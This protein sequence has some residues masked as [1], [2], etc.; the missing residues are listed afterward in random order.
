MRNMLLHLNHRKTIK[1]LTIMMAFGLVSLLFIQSLSAQNDL[2]IPKPDLGDGSSSM[3]RTGAVSFTINGKVYIGLGKDGS[4][5]HQDLWEYDTISETWTQKADFVGIGRIGAFSMVMNNKAI[6]GTGELAGGSRTNTVYKYDP[7]S[8]NW[9]ALTDFAGGVRSYASAFSI[10]T[11]GFVV[12]GD[13]GAFQNDLWEYNIN[14]D[15]WIGRQAFPGIARMKAVAFTLG[16]NAYYGT[17]DI[18]AGTFAVDFWEYNVTTD[19]WTQLA[20]FPGTARAGAVGCS[21]GITGYIGLGNDGS[22]LQDFWSFDGAAWTQQSDFPANARELAVATVS[23]NKVYAG[24]G[25]GAAYY[26][27][28]YQWDPCAVP[29]ITVNPVGLD[30]CEGID[31]SFTVEISNTGTETY[32][33]LLDGSPVAGGTS[34]TL[35]LTGV[36][37]AEEGSYTCKITNT[38]GTAVSDAAIL[39]VTPLPI[40]PPTGVLANPDTLCPDNTFDITLTADNNGNNQDTL[41]WYANGCGGDLLGTGFPVNNQVQV[42]PPSPPVSVE[43]YVRWEN[44]CGTTDCDTVFIFA[45]EAA[46]EPTSISTSIDTICNGFN[47]SLF[48]SVEGGSGDYV[49]W[50]KGDICNNSSAP[51]IDTGMTIDLLTAGQIP[52]TTQTYSAR[53]ETYCGGSEFHS[54]CL[55]VDVA[56]N[57]EFSISQQPQNKSR[58]EGTDTVTF[59]IGVD[60]G[61]SLTNI[62]YQWFFEGNAISGAQSDTLMVF[63]IVPADSGNYYCKVYNTCDTIFSD[64]AFLTVNLKPNIVIEPSVVDTICE[65]DSLTFSVQAEGSDILQYLW[66]FNDVPTAVT[67]T[68]YTVNPATFANTG[69]YYCVVTNGC[70]VDTSEVVSF[71]VDTIPYVT[72]QPEDQIV[73]LNGTAEFTTLYNGSNP[74][75]YQ[76]YKIDNGGASSV[77][78]GETGTNLEITPVLAADTAFDYF[79][80]ASNQCFDGISSDTVSLEMYAP[81]E[82]MDSIV[83]DTNNVCYTYPNYIHLT[84][85]GGEGDTIRWFKDSCEG[86]ELAATIDTVYNIVVPDLTTT[87]YARWENTCGISACDSITITVAQEPEVMDTLFFED[88][89]ICYNAYDSILLTAAG[90]NGDSIRWF[91]GFNCNGTPFAVTSDTFVYVHNIPLNST[92]YAAQYVNTCGES[93]CLVVNLYIKDITYIANQT[94]YLEVCENSSS[95]MYVEAGGDEPFNY[96][97]YQNGSE[98]A[99]EIN[100]TLY[101]SPVSFADTGMYYCDV[102]TACDTAVSDSIHLEMLE[103]PYFTQQAVD[104][105]VCEG[106]SAAIQIKVAGDMP[107]LVQWYKNGQEIGGSSLL[108]T[109]LIINPVY[110]TADYYAMIS[111]GCGIAYSDTITQRALDTLVILEQPQYQNLCLLDTAEFYVSVESTEFVSYS[112]QKVGGTGSIGNDSI[113]RIPNLDYEDQGMYFC[114]ISDTCGELSSDTALLNMNTPP[115]VITDPFGATV[116][117]GALF[118]FEAVFNADADSLTYEWN[119]NGGWLPDTDTSILVFNP[120]QRGDEG[121]YYIRAFNNCG[122]DESVPVQLNVDYLPD[123]LEALEVIPDTVCPECIY[124]SLTLIAIGDGGGYGD[125]IEWYEGQVGDA[126]IIGTGDT[127]KAP[128]PTATTEYFARWVNDCTDENGTGSG[129]GN[130][131]GSCEALSLTVVYQGNPEPPTNVS[132]NVNNFCVINGDSIVLSGE[133]GYGDILKWY[134]IEGSD[135]IYIGRGESLTVAQPM[136]TT[137]YAAKWTNHCGHSDSVVVQVNVVALPEAITIESDS[138]C[139]G[140]AYEIENVFV[141]HYD[142]LFWTSNHPDGYFDTANIRYPIYYNN[143]ISLLDTSYQDLVLTAYGQADCPDTYDTINLVSFPLPPIAITPD[144]P[145]ICRDSSIEITASGADMFYF[146]DPD[147]PLTQ[148]E[149]NPVSLSPI[150]THTYQLVGTSES[151]CVDSMNFTVDVYPTPLVDLGDSVFLFSCEPVQL[152]AGG[153]DGSEY[154]IWSNGYRTR[155]ITVYETGNYSVIVGNPGCEVSDKG[156]ISLCNGRIY[157]PNAFTPNEDGINEKFKPITA[158]PSVEFHMSI[159]DRW[160][161]MIF[162]TYD[163]HEGW[164]GN[165][166]GEPCPTGNYVWRIDYQGQGTESPGKKGSDVGTVMLVR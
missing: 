36:T 112:W 152:D 135:E 133:G 110:E 31:V 72:Q 109:L 33:W 16:A 92:S 151:G 71:E 42:T 75:S 125:Y 91:E 146:I 39:S 139:A 49:A 111:N 164:D 64:S 88:N 14:S 90:G 54:I 61:G 97:W 20:D 136:D 99:G 46:V 5:Y 30:V 121:T 63:D 77:M 103:L 159:F 161:K 149:D 22:F 116:C 23:G 55:L 35:D 40:N 34:S 158:D 132:V 60:E 143:M 52:T 119:Y 70:G 126:Y 53:W 87:F 153:G 98:I 6:I 123:L 166:E 67:D 118:Q 32:E 25:F 78:T 68:F 120:V 86:E 66:H 137:L 62:Y 44:Q 2:W 74:I 76:W 128:L 83:S 69:D 100:D 96:Q 95:F 106:D 1:Q 89:N 29:Q 101:V 104:T 21:N 13:D 127:L 84:V 140:Q 51:L 19:S 163:I 43:Y 102:W 162:E 113:L 131:G 130:G 4:T 108:D 12:G 129:G 145:A 7:G 50:Y 94:D 141:D 18:G 17:G 154:Y 93:E 80:M 150:E 144:M 85:Y 41:R 11:R 147:D 122:E 165:F 105:A 3:K 24:T 82:I 156:Y 9:S 8:N 117:E 115:Q 15:T 134:I 81:V 107:I 48:L 124:D 59:Q 155:S 73:C 10:G 142:S 38:C 47:D 114:I 45:K 157:M 65:G 79:C 148:I 57:G 56:V 160:G 26:K 138:I 27:D 28:F 37:E 58:C